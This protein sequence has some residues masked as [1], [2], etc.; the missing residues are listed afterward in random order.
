M[1]LK[2]RRLHL[3]GEIG[4]NDNPFTPVSPRNYHA[5]RSRIQYRARALTPGDGSQ[6]NYNNDSIQITAWS[7]DAR[8][9]SA[10]ASWNA[11]SWVSLDAT[12]S[13][14]HLD[15]I[16]G[17]DFFAGTP[18]AQEV[19]GMQSIYVSNIQAANLGL[20]FALTKR[21][22]LHVG[23]NIT[24]DTGDGRT[25]LAPQATPV[26]Q[27]FLYCATTSAISTTGKTSGS[28]CSPLTRTS[29][30]TP[31]IRAFYGRSDP[32]RTRQIAAPR[33]ARRERGQAESIVSARFPVGRSR[34]F[35]PAGYA[36][37]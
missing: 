20:R 25:S 28:V 2:N 24:K 35:F 32:R 9:Y 5:I 3:E 34:A 31:G 17:I 22:D 27:V 19:T 37:C 4:R 11:R 7:S 8:N 1:P 26:G 10:E 6:E 14:L 36:N 13:K 16:G 23:Y 33:L 21:A 18:F 12:W 30:P 29:M 15:T